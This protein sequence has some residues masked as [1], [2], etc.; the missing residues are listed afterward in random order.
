[1]N[2]KLMKDMKKKYIAPSLFCVKIV[3]RG[4]MLQSSIDKFDTGADADVVLTKEYN[5]TFPNRN[6]WDEEW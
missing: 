1:M 3:T 5:N 6:V 4:A 2:S